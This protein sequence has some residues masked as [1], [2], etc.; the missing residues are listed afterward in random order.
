MPSVSLYTVAK[1]APFHQITIKQLFLILA[2]PTF[3]E[4]CALSFT[5]A[6]QHVKF[7]HIFLTVLMSK[8]NQHSFTLY[9][10]NHSWADHICTIPAIAKLGRRV[11]TAAQF[12]TAL[13]AENW[14]DHCKL[15]GLEGALF[16]VSGHLSTDPTS[17]AFVLLR[18]RSFSSCHFI[19]DP[20][21][22]S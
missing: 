4:L 10:S 15:G 1:K 7:P 17:Q 20:S 16:V 2:L 11:G 22:I 5:S 18:F 21:H 6:Y 14:E 13:L 9:L 3:L 12:D 19:L 8:T